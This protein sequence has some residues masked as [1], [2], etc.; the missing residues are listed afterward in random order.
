MLLIFIDK[1]E[2]EDI[3]FLIREQSVTHNDIRISKNC[4]LTRERLFE[5]R[6]V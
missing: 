4:G 3:V 6:R 5:W 1:Y 2:Y